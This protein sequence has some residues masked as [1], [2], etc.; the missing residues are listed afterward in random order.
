[1]AMTDGVANGLDRYRVPKD[2]HMAA[3]MARRHPAELVNAVHDAEESDADGT[4][5]RR[6]KLHD[7]KAI[8][9]VEFTRTAS[10]L[11]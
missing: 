7:D 10:R 9:L 11:P 6:S 1:M 8:V 2:W 4:R 3:E 5:W